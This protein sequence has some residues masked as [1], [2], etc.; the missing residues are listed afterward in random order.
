MEQIPEE[1][2]YIQ[3]ATE[4]SHSPELTKAPRKV[5]REAR[6]A[7]S[8]AELHALLFLHAAT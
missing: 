6:A 4:S 7:Q 3:A 1:L 2:G 5:I 8:C